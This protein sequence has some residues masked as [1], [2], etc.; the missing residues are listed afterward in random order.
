LNALELFAPFIVGSDYRTRSVMRSGEARSA[1]QQEVGCFREARVT[2]F[3]LDVTHADAH[4]LE[5]V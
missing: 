5:G 2:A 4:T 3:S 1:L